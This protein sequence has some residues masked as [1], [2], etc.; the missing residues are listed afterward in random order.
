[1]PSFLGQFYNFEFLAQALGFGL[2][3]TSFANLE[4]WSWVEKLKL[5]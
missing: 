3:K 1:V 4:N 2:A 5:E